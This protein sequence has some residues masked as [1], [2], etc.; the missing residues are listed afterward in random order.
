MKIIDL[1][2]LKKFI[3]TYIFTV[4]V[5]VTIICVIDY[6]EKVEQFAESGLTFK[7]IFIDY[8]INLFPFYANML[9]PLTIFIAAVF[10]T[11]KMASH[12]EI[13]AI[14]SSGISFIRFLFPFFFGAFLVAIFTF[15][16]TNYGIPYANKTRV[17]FEIA[18]LNNPFKFSETNVHLK[19]SS[20]LYAYLERYDNENHV[21]YNFSLEQ[22]DALKLK[23]KLTAGRIKWDTTKNKWKI[24]DYTLRI[25]EKN[26]T[27][28]L[29]F[30]PGTDTTL[31]FKPK[32]FENSYRLVET[33][34]LPEL[35]NFINVQRMRGADNLEQYLIDKYERMTY[36]FAIIVL[37]LMGVIVSARKS[38]QGIGFQI[39][40]G[41]VLAF[42][43]I[44]LVVTTRNIAMVG[45]V[46]PL[47]AAWIPTGIFTVVT[48][49]LYHSVPR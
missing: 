9:S 39:A 11:S 4:L 43:F 15:F 32:D 17:A 35:N 18:Y 41:F 3:T 22:I 40:L 24:S 31:N 42:T 16:V 5:L 8:Y 30:K 46:D 36:P 23:Q 45:G 1:Y 7:T 29:I 34:T 20:D 6:T 48:F 47:I 2:I 25:I 28:K 49:V 27:E 37:T 12:T 33:L 19:I 21:G 13:I 10:V 26:G 38:R 44:I 14:L